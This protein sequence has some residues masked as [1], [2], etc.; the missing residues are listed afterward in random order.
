MTR[1]L[2]GAA[3]PPSLPPELAKDVQGLR[4]VATAAAGPAATSSGLVRE[5]AEV[6]Q[7]LDAERADVDSARAAHAAAAADEQTL[8]LRLQRAQVDL[9]RNGRSA[10]RTPHPTAP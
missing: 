4:A 3:L 10:P 6:D 1:H 8:L 9:V 7:L 5:L 2:K